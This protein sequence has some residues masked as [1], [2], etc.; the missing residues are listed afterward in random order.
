M[1]NSN[2]VLSREEIIFEVLEATGLNWSVR[3]EPL[4]TQTSGI[5]IPDKVSAI[6]SDNGAYLGIVGDGYQHLQN[7][8]MVSLIYDSA[9]EVFDS[10]SEI[11]HP[12]NNSETLGSFG[13]MGGGSLKG[14]TRV[15]AQMQL[16][17]KLIGKS[18]VKRFISGTNGHDGTHGFGFG[19][20]NQ[21]ICCANTFAIA[22]RDL[23]KIK[24]TASMQQRID[25]AVKSL[26][27]VLEFEERQME[28]FEIAS[29]RAF[30]K[31]HIEDIV[32]SVFGV[33]VDSKSDDISTRMKNQMV[34]FSGDIN[35]SIQEQ[36][37]TLWA[38][39]N[40]VTRYTNHTQKTKDKD[41]GLM[42]GN[43]AQINQR[44]YEQMVRWLNEPLLE[45]VAL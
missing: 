40:G 33:K 27:K 6:R 20:S 29:S 14:G 18:G 44:A 45:K 42:F 25:E 12:W 24:H 31:K 35:Q 1:Q 37:E 17:E 22:N 2:S 21:V 36:G 38:L 41:F 8:D 15:F 19:T 11:K 30:D 7:S 43:E 3:K 9:K 26:R 13:N 34:D 5:I 32:L 10:E 4:V 23:A 16:P 28:V 39:F